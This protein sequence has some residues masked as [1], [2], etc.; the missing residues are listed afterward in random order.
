MS[1]PS[2]LSYYEDF[3]QVLR[4]FYRRKTMQKFTVHRRY[5]PSRLSDTYL[6]DAYEQLYKVKEVEENENSE[7]LCK[8]LIETTSTGEYNRESDCRARMS[9]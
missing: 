6:A 4:K 1:F 3:K 9:H 5:E 2:F 7:L 8:S